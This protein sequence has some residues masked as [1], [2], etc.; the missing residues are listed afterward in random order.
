MMRSLQEFWKLLTKAPRKALIHAP[1]VII[2]PKTVK[3]QLGLDFGTSCT[4]M[5]FSQAGR[6]GSRIITWDHGLQPVYPSFAIPSVALINQD[7]RLLFGIE[8]ARY[9]QKRRWDDGLRLL[10]VLVAGQYD[11]SFQNDPALEAFNSHVKQNLGSEDQ[12]SPDLITAL[13]LA[14]SI[15]LAKKIIR[16]MPEFRGSRIDLSVNICVPIDHIQ[17]NKVWHAFKNIFSFSYSL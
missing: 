6:R 3:L 12:V 1:S 10:K 16:K 2:P 5:V 14:Y 8:A 7:E 17:S 9:L 4:K 15:N 13:F 11:M